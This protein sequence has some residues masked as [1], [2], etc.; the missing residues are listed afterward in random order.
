MA[1]I[2]GNLRWTHAICFL[3]DI[4][5]MGRTLDEHL[6]RLDDVLECIEKSGMKI[7][8][9]KCHFLETELKVLGHIVSA[10]GVACDPAK[11]KAVSDFPEPPLNAPRA[12]QIKHL[13]AYLGLA[14][15]Y[16]RMVP[17]FALIAMP[18]TQLLKKNAEFVW[19][20]EQRDSFNAIKQALVNSAINAFPKYDLPMHLYTDACGYGIG[21]CLSQR[22][23]GPEEPECPLAFI[24]RLLNK[25]E[26]NYS[27]CELEL[28]ATVWS[29]KKLRPITW[30]CKVV[31]FSDNSALSY[32][33]RKRDLVGRPARWVLSILEDDVEIR[34]RSGKLQEHVDCLSR[35]PVEDPDEE[36]FE[37]KYIMS[38]SAL[39][40]RGATP[41]AREGDAP[42]QPNSPS[43]SLDKVYARHSVADEKPRARL[44]PIEEEEEAD[45]K[46]TEEPASVLEEGSEAKRGESVS[47]RQ[48]NDLLLAEIGALQREEKTW[49][50][51]IHQ[52]EKGTKEM[53]NNYFLRNNLL[54]RVV[55]RNG[56]T[57]ERLCLPEKYRLQMLRIFHDETATGSHMGIT[58]VY[59]RI[60]S[61]FYWRGLQNDVINYVTACPDCQTRK[62][63]YEKPAG[64]MVCV[65]VERPF[66]RCVCDLLG[67]FPATSDGKKF[68]IVL[69]DKLTKY[70]EADAI[71]SANAIDTAEFF[72]KKVLLRHGLMKCLQTDNGTNYVSELVRAVTRAFKTSHKTSS[73]FRPQSQGIVER[74]NHTIA[75][76]LSM[77]VN[78]DQKNWAEVLPYIIFAWNTS[79]H[80]ATGFTPFFLMY[81]REAEIPTDLEFDVSANP[82][83][84]AA[85]KAIDY[86]KVLQ[87]R[88][89][90][91][92][93]L[94]AN[95][96]VALDKSRK[97]KYDEGRRDVTYAEGDLALVYRP[98]RQVGKSDKLQHCY[99]GPYVVLK[100]LTSVNYEVQFKGKKKTQVVHVAQMKP[101]KEDANQDEEVLGAESD[102]EAVHEMLT[103]LQSEVK[104]NRGRPKK[105]IEVPLAPL[106]G[107]K[108]RSRPR[109]QSPP[110]SQARSQSPV[111][112][113]PVEEEGKRT[114]SHQQRRAP[115]R[116]GVAPE[117]FESTSSSE[118][119]ESAPLRVRGR[120]KGVGT[121]NSVFL[122]LSLCM[123]L[124]TAVH[125][126]ERIVQRG[127][128]V[129][130]E[131]SRV[132][133]SESTWT[134]STGLTFGDV[135]TGLNQMSRWL[136]RQKK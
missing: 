42:V 97:E 54:R 116:L 80:E 111:I 38:I 113:P 13:Q 81:N 39:L 63:S 37:E 2:L 103:K 120:K 90:T 47:D 69:V 134:V 6:S 88:L 28:L 17:N 133:F 53:V 130:Q 106:T 121:I 122:A 74:L 99:L 35:Y 104:R 24:S 68:I 5:T 89:N 66:D 1:S 23:N 15:F 3:D 135:S 131:T 71:P 45:Q 110:S 44:P 117:E 107:P 101:F 57:Y 128:V 31:V 10:K 43:G 26:R 100:K 21:G 112:L 56:L 16:R 92:H 58:R 65:K 55:I 50:R 98:V 93:D 62:R 115:V 34:Y 8:L 60:S 46:M 91:A 19:E 108:K 96:L 114:R 102:Q 70:C 40:E 83:T 79:R 95:R 72:I 118:E 77:Y 7:K 41:P 73:P 87:Q 105:T 9:R 52:L 18:L 78:S 85:T 32:L 4:V 124:F 11:V 12:K 30:G 123:T 51:I 127:G 49:S 86:V 36:E 22:Q 126:L 132:A 125:S 109:K 75:E 94:V 33:L 61:R 27:I 48:S 59:D 136:D 64:K 129:F 14:N 119:E 25:A 20:K 67:P 84:M 82:V 29:L 76:M